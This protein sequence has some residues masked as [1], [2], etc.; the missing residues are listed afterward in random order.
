MYQAIVTS[1]RGPTNSRGSR[2]I[3]KA[4]AGRMAVPWDHALSPSENH[5]AAALAFARRWGWAESADDLIGGAMP[6]GGYCF[7]LRNR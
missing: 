2:V 1:Y 7:V 5:S 3:V 4:Q 6:N